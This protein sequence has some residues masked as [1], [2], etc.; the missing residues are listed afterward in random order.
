[1]YREEK[2]SEYPSEDTHT[3]PDGDI[4]PLADICPQGG[5]QLP[6]I[7]EYFCFIIL[8]VPVFT[9]LHDG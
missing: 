8:P 5:Y 4:C 3:R 9:K 6:D 1:M 7:I 2:K